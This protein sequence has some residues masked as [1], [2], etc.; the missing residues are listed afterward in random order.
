MYV[1]DNVEV[2]F[3]LMMDDK[4]VNEVYNIGTDNTFY[5]L[6]LVKKISEIIGKDVT[7]E[8]VTDRLGH[9]RKYN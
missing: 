1:K 9:D 5:N 2:I 4:V 6:E 8:F 3:D 7:F